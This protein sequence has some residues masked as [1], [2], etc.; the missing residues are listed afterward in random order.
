MQ[1]NASIS[2]KLNQWLEKKLEKIP[3]NGYGHMIDGNS[4]S[5]FFLS[6]LFN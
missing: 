2:L 4:L 3:L 1:M 5:F 6:S